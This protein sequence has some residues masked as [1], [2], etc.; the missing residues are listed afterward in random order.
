MYLQLVNSLF[1]V[2]VLRQVY[3]LGTAVS[4]ARINGLYIDLAVDGLLGVY[5]PDELEVW[6]LISAQAYL[7]RVSL[8]VFL[9]SANSRVVLSAF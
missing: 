9:A 5:P 6:S 8:L 1:H 3:S 7:R 4:R 2:V